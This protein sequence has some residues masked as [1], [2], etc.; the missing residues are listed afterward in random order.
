MKRFIKLQAIVLAVCLIFNMGIVQAETMSPD[1]KIKNI[2]FFIPDGGGMTAFNMADAVKQAG[3]FNAGVYPYA[4]PVEKGE[5]YLKQYWVGAET[6][7]S[8]SH[9]VTDSAAGGTAL[10]TGKKTTNKYIGVTPDGVPIA[11]ILEASQRSGKNTGIVVTCKWTDATPATFSAHDMSRYDGEPMIAQQMVNQ[12]IDV[13]LGTT[14]TEYNSYSFHTDEYL[15]GKGYEVI[16]SKTELSSVK[17]GDRLWSKFSINPNYDISNKALSPTIVD[18]TKAAITALNDGNE[19]GFFLMVEGSA[20]DGGGHANEP[21]PMVGDFLAFDAACQYAIEFAKGRDDTIVIVAPDHDTGGMHWDDANLEAIVEQLKAG[22]ETEAE[23]AGLNWTT[24]SHTNWDGGVF[25]YAPEGVSYP[26]G[27]DVSKR[28]AAL[29]EFRSSGFKVAKTNRIDNTDIPKYLAGFI[30]VDLDELSKDLFVDVTDQGTYNAS[31]KTFV[32]DNTDSG[33]I[34]VKRNESVALHNGVEVDL[35]GEVTVYCNERFYVPQKLIEKTMGSG[36]SFN[37]TDVT[38]KGTYNS[39]TEIFT[40]E[41]KDVTFKNLSNILV[42]KGQEISMNEDVAVYLNNKFF[43]P[44]KALELIERLES[45][46]FGKMS[47]IADCNTHKINVS[48]WVGVPN[49]KVSMMAVE[50][51]TNLAEDF[52]ATK[53]IAMTELKA[54]YNGDYSTSIAVQDEDVAGNYKFYINYKGSNSK[55]AKSS[56]FTFKNSVPAMDVLGK[57]GG[58]LMYMEQLEVGDSVNVILRGFDHKENF[59]GVAVIAQYDKDNNLISAKLFDDVDNDSVERGSEIH[60]SATVVSGAHK[61]KVMYW[62]HNTLCPVFGVYTI[63]TKN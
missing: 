16:K 21:L 40:F 26:K 20:I 43:V 44:N 22:K 25:I 41:D 48:G 37:N 32:F 55:E 4:T 5:M 47:V 12:G 38:D 39:A 29:E 59:D 57:D 2:I 1:S 51:G 45:G 63:H 14:K 50:E 7:Y 34:M 10:S 11:N 35:E 53:I 42:Y 9:A 17:A 18:M 28:D 8:A 31:T 54:D 62:E 56:S 46:E 6:T 13:L 24:T 30:G 19:N 49:A 58:E 33:L 23:E 3:G 27:I 52:D 61:I 36:A 15:E 60:K